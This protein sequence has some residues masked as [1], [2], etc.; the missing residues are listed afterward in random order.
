[1]TLTGADLLVRAAHDEGVRLCLTHPGAAELPLVRSLVREPGVRPVLALCE[2]VA[3]GVADGY[4]RVARRPA[5]VLMRGPGLAHA[6]PNLHHARRAYSSVVSVVGDHATTQPAGDARGAAPLEAIAAAVSGWHATTQSV[7]DA[8]W[9]LIDAVGAA[10]SGRCPATLVVPV[11]VQEAE[12]EE[13]PVVLAERVRRAPVGEDRVVDCA[14]RIFSAGRVVLLVGGDALRAEALPYLERLGR[15][16]GVRCYAEATPALAERGSGR[17]TLP[18]LPSGPEGAHRVLRR[19]DLVVLVGA[20][21]PASVCTEPERLPPGASAER[22]VV[23]CGPV[24][25]CAD[26]LGRLVDALPP[27]RHQLQLAPQPAADGHREWDT[28]T[29]AQTIAER[30]P[31]HAVLS[32]EDDRWADAVA[33]AA[34]TAAPHTLLSTPG[35]PLGQGLPVAVGAALAAPHRSVLAVQSPAGAHYTAPALWTVAREELDVTVVIPRPR[36]AEPRHQELRSADGRPR[37]QGAIRLSSPEHPAVGWAE[38]AAGYGVPV[39]TAAT[40]DELDQALATAFAE[41][42]PHLVLVDV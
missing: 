10:R 6:A 19:A 33:E 5:M 15:R 39:E 12:A 16:P 41:P 4:A 1:M 14:R 26:A 29:A 11:D 18:L 23:L 8:G 36:P 35:G 3:T 31:Q 21:P 30:L 13:L 32:L 22:M 9:D 27:P 42:G 7:A 34:A 38:I 40:R 25:A 2:G 20:P 37:P 28:A 17:P 24:D